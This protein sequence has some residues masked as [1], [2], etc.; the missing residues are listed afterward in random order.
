MQNTPDLTHFFAIHRK[1]R[2][3]TR[4]FARAV[5]TATSD[6]RGGRLVPL[7][8]WAKGFA[9]ELDEHHFVEDTYFFPE[10]RARIPS[11]QTFLDELDADHRVVDGILSRWTRVVGGLA[12]R[13][14]PF[15]SAK[16]EALAMAVTLRDLLHRHLDVEDRDILPLYWRHYSREEFDAVYQQAVNGGKKKGLSFV[17]PWNVECLEPADRATLIGRAPLPLKAVWWT[18]RGRF[19]RLETSAFA[20]IEVD[21]SDLATIPGR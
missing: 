14:V 11:A 21:V 13:S 15:V 10:L 2:I 3:D 18:T 7:R 4:R 20:G 5:E 9:F 19:R 1:M 16:E 6:D 17:V 8:R 12:D